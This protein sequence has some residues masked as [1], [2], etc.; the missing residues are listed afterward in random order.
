MYVPRHFSQTDPAVLHELID[1]YSFGLLVVNTPDGPEAAHLPFVL[2][3][4]RGPQSN[5]NGSLRCHVARANPIWQALENEQTVLAVFTGPHTYISPDWYDSPQLVPTWNYAAVHA[6]AKPKLMDDTEL[7]KLLDDLSAVNENR[8]LPKPPWTNGK[9]PEDFFAKLRKAI[10]GIDL[11]IT[12]LEGK[13][14]MSQNRSA[15]DRAR[16]MR[17]LE[18]LGGESQLAVASLMERD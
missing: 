12:R 17:E 11:E 15:A 7:V 2:D 3:R 13:S 9:L 1:Q 16:V 4:Q 6:Y 5:D 10:V 8:L 18:A 14:K